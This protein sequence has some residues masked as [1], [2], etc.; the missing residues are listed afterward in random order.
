VYDGRGEACRPTVVGA[1][2]ETEP[3]HRGS[4]KEER[5]DDAATCSRAAQEAAAMAMHSF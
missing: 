5:I 2:K 1:A 3:R 4:I